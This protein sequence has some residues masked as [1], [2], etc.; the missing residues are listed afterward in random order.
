MITQSLDWSVGYTTDPCIAPK[1]FYNAAV[2]GSVQSDYAKAMHLPPYHYETNFS[3]YDWMEDMYWIYKT[4]LFFHLC[5]HQAASLT[6][7]GIDYRYTIKI[8][9]EIIADCEGMFT[10]FNTDISHYAEI[11]HQL[12]VIIHPVPKADNSFT[13]SQAR[14]S[15]KPAA[16]YGWDWH[17]RLISSGIFDDAYLVIHDSRHIEQFDVS[18]T[19]NDALDRC[20]LHVQALLSNDSTIRVQLCENTDI[21]VANDIRNCI[22]GPCNFTL[23]INSPKLWYPRGYGSQTV[24]TLKVATLDS[25]GSVI[26]EHSRKIGFRRSRLVMNDGSWA[27]PKVFPKSRSDAPAT[28]EINGIR[29]FAKGSN[30]VN[31]H[32]F[33]GHLSHKDYLSL[34]T[35]VRDANMNMLRIWGGGFVNH[36]VFYEL[37]D[38]MGIMV[39]QE[40]PLACNEYPDD[41]HYLSVL[42]Q[43]ATSIVRRLRT[44]PCLVLWCGGN[45]LF[46][47]WSKMTDQHHALRLLDKICYTEDRF[48]PFI[49][50]SPLN[51]MAHGH[52]LNYDEQTQEEFI[53][54]L[55]QSEN[56]AYT[57]F[58]SPGAADPNYIRQYISPDNY[59][60]CN[61]NNH[62]WTGHHAFNAWRSET[63]LRKPE[64]EYYFG[65]YT[66]IDDL[67]KKT[68]FIQTMC[69][70]SYFEE[71]RKQWPHCSMA[72]NWCFNEPWP[73]FANNSLI[74][75]PDI[76]KPSYFAVQAA[77]RPQL[78]SLRV[79][80]HLWW[81]GDIFRA[82]VWVLNDC[83]RELS[84]QEVDVFYSLGNE[85]PV[86]WG[87]LY[88]PN[89]TAQ[90]N[91]LCGAIS[92]R[93]SCNQADKIHIW[94]KVPHHPEMN[95]KY[96]YLCRTRNMISTA[97]MLN[98]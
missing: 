95:S 67:C 82:E 91:H 85:E 54:T 19:L 22:A 57:E 63:W 4:T 53:T 78:A 71:M 51:G 83:L 27:Y 98:V 97:G 3:E 44:H 52:Y 60:D 94:L 7:R 58:G 21:V 43:E 26:E 77:L 65:G 56:T 70:Q 8:D 76:P 62:V 35:L 20:Q 81:T 68:Q 30:W 93:L 45:E 18:Y 1:E 69:Y 59:T 25:E 48:T 92:F 15:C 96:T 17:P 24:Y 79:D 28:I 87:T 33:P 16:C 5:E 88:A 49:M 90:S 11:P 55:V 40:F 80:R 46:N 50:T 38:E 29:I 66:D 42:E 74:S 75:W 12:E 32:I 64:V 61:L 9:D 41:N 2:P 37:C 86:K 36:E 10:P 13:R 72:L 47:G 89:T 73:T 31:A 6:F 39:W 34:L 23:I 84:C 14:L